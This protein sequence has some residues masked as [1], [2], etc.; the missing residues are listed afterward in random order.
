MRRLFVLLATAMPV[1]LTIGLTIGLATGVIGSAPAA[2]AGTCYNEGQW[3]DLYNIDLGNGTAQYWTA[4]TTEASDKSTVVSEL[5]YEDGTPAESYWCRVV[6]P[7]V[8]TI[9]Y[10]AY[11]LPGTSECATWNNGNDGSANGS[12]SGEG[13]V[14]LQPCD[15]G[16]G[17]TVGVASQ[18]WF[19]DSD[20]GTGGVTLETAYQVNDA[21]VTTCLSAD[22]IPSGSG[23]S[24][25]L[26][27]SVKLVMV[28]SDSCAG[29][30]GQTW[31]YSLAVPPSGS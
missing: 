26:G 8:G 4:T 16:S 23:D 6:G 20:N 15:P 11:R 22:E 17:D 18:D 9:Q 24:G 12:A 7:D 31:T 1:A 10:Y 30:G 25:N 13:W 29:A 21:T 28:D 2:Q 14:D 5:A 27:S 19:L 3:S